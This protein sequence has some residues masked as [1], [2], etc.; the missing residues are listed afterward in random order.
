MKKFNWEKAE[1]NFIKETCRYANQL[2]KKGKKPGIRACHRI[3]L[4]SFGEIFSLMLKFMQIIIKKHLIEAI[5]M[6]LKGIDSDLEF[7]LEFR[8]FIRTYVIDWFY[9]Y[10][11]AEKIFKTDKAVSK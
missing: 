8:E 9:A 6:H 11:D 10:C 7:R 4:N 2:K 1:K 3:C 5:D